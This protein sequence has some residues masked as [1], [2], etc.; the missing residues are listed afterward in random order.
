MYVVETNDLDTKLQD[1]T[2][3]EA[4]YDYGTYKNP[5]QWFSHMKWYWVVSGIYM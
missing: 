2:W 5:V 4:C 1:K 3:S